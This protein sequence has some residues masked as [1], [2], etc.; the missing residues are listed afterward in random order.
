[1]AQVDIPESQVSA[2]LRMID[3][4][5][6]KLDVQRFLDRFQVVC[7]VNTLFVQ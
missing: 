4:D 2:L 6:G 3:R 7:V 1:M 5:G